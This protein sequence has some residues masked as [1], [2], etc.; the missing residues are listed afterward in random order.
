MFFTSPLAVLAGLALASSALITP[1]VAT[2]THSQDVAAWGPNGNGQL[3]NNTTTGSNVPVAVDT[4]GALAG[5]TITAI[6]GGGAHSCAVADGQ[7]YCWGGNDYGQL[8]NNT[9]T[10]SLVPVAVDN[11]SGA[12]AG[13]N[14]TAIDAGSHHTCAVADGQAFCWGENYSGQLGNNTITDSLVPAAVDTTSGVLAGKT[15]TAITTG[16]A[17]SCALANGQ[18][19][20]WGG[21]STGQLGNNA[22]LKSKVPVAVNTSSGALAGK[23]VTAITGGNLHTCSLA[24][25]QAFCWGD[26]SAGQ[27]GDGS[28]LESLVPIAVDTSGVLPDKAVTAIT[29]G[30]RHTCA[31]AAGKATCWGS[32]VSGQLGDNKTSNSSV[33]VAVDTAGVLAGKNLTAIATGGAFTCAMTDATAYCWGYNGFGALGDNTFSSSSVPVAVDTSGV[34]AGRAVTAITAGGYHALVVTVAVPVVSVPQPPTAVAGVAGDAKVT[35]SWSAPADDGGSPVLDYVPIA[36]PGGATC[37]TSATSCI[38]SGL[39]NGTAY[40]F[41][42]TARN[43]QGVSAPSAPSAP[44]TPAAPVSPKTRVIAKPV[45]GRSKLK[46]RVKPSVGKKKQWTFVVKKRRNGK[47]RTLKT[48]SGKIKVYATRGPK[49]TRVL[50]LGKGKYKARSRALRGYRPD[51]SKVVRLKR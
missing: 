26:N 31:L 18:A 5:K 47:W 37:T 28:L 29:A 43:A 30:S 48:K 44:V 39:T 49:H 25:G 8:G 7:V 21:N 13:K 17:H 10:D 9:T 15:I 45:A 24:D 20:C 38:V 12:L 51:T 2:S 16:A 14:V 46:V 42:V 1:A 34:L 40:T 6:S 3:G 4:T 36:T 27:L 22:T 23:T 41:T 19:F 33:P 11:T 32:D 35:V 50:N